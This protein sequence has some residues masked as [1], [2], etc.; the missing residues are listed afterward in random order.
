MDSNNNT[1]I[2]SSSH[3][4]FVD[5]QDFIVERFK[6]DSTHDQSS[7]RGDSSNGTSSDD[8]SSQ[9]ISMNTTTIENSFFTV[10]NSTLF[11][12]D[13]VITKTEITK[14]FHLGYARQ[15]KLTQK[16]RSQFKKEKN[17]NSNLTM[18]TTMLLQ[19]P[20]SLPMIIY[21]MVH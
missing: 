12:V 2:P 6:D 3:K 7:L 20:F 16:K 8:E 14:N 11:S 5:I 4:N 15:R 9:K 13:T 19:D 1:T 18:I 21:S 17:S 10:P